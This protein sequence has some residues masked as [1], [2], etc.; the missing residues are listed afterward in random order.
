MYSLI[1]REDET[2]PYGIGIGF[3]Q[4]KMKTNDTWATADA[5]ESEFFKLLKTFLICLQGHISEVFLRRNV[6][7]KTEAQVRNMLLMKGESEIKQV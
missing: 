5:F 1:K 2:A 6:T 3:K 4:Y 7:D